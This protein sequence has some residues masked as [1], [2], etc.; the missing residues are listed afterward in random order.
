MRVIKP[1][2]AVL[3]IFTSIA[4]ASPIQYQFGLG[5]TSLTPDGGVGSFYWDDA[6][7][8]ISN[9]TWDFGGGLTGGSNDANLDWSADI[10][11][12]GTF[13][14]LAFEVLTGQDVFA[15]AVCGC[16]FGLAGTDILGSAARSYGFPGTFIAFGRIAG[17][18]TYQVQ[19]NSD[20]SVGTFQGA[21]I[22]PTAVPE[23]GILGL[24][25]LGLLGILISRTRRRV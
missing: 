6:T 22:A 20:S 19:T 12:G 15:G 7:H 5:A 24:M 16:A 18:L 17:V 1:L 14:E 10:G 8:L 3:G 2:I 21:V 23:P 9:I 25:G 13:S 4:N 11:S